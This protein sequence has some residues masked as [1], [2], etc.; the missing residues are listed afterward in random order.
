MITTFST[1]KDTDFEVS[2]EK[3][4]SVF[5]FKEDFARK[6]DI[7]DTI[8]QSNNLI[9]L[10][11]EEA[12]KNIKQFKNSRTLEQLGDVHFIKKNLTRAKK[13]YLQAIEKNNSLLAVYEKIIFILIVEKNIEEA[14]NYHR[15]LLKITSRRSDYLH[16]Y[17][18]FKLFFLNKKY[19]R[20]ESFGDIKEVLEKNP[21]DYTALNTFGFLY[22]QERN[23]KEGNLY[24]KEALKIN[25]EFIYSLNNSGVCYQKQ[26]KLEKAKSYYKMAIKK[27]PM[28]SAPY[29]NL[30][31]YYISINKLKNALD[32]LTEATS[33]SVALSNI[34]QHQIGWLNIKLF[35][36]DDAI[37]WY[38]ER[39][40]LEPENDL[41]YNNLGYCYIQI[42]KLKKGANCLKYAINIFKKKIKKGLLCT[43]KELLAFYNLGRIAVL[44]GK[45]ENIKKIYNEIL[46]YSPKDAFA[47]YLRGSENRLTGK[48]D[49]AKRLYLDSLKKRTDIPEVYLDLSFVLESIYE[50]YSSAIT[51]LEQAIGMNFNTLLITNNLI[52]A[53]IEN[54]DFSKAEKLLSLFKKEVPPII[55]TNKGLLAFRKNNDIEKGNYYYERAIKGLPDD[56][57][58]LAKQYWF[59]EKCKYYIKNKDEAAAK[60]YLL[61]LRKHKDTYLKSRI[62]KIDNDFKKT[63]C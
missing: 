37:K 58:I 32:I 23:F 26:G 27:D 10:Q 25:P 44:D 8:S 31:N 12:K 35:N 19:T 63:F 54:N 40:K 57:K 20:E 43:D 52:Y 36:Y 34:W 24:F 47:D 60:K 49:E 14:D 2:R 22:L 11:W 7:F 51:L 9:A 59:S 28:Y 39:V 5:G 62:E 38:E 33:K 3:T 42:G 46:L 29:E 30:S 61:F 55:Y 1:K 16:R 4:E 53:Y 18:L 13:Y 56:N 21:N 6:R 15:M 45:I 41:L 48:Y 50:D 17:I